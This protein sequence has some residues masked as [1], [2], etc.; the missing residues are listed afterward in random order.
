MLIDARNGQLLE[1][2]AMKPDL[3]V[4]I[5]PQESAWETRCREIELATAEYENRLDTQRPL[6]SSLEFFCSVEIINQLLALLDSEDETLRLQPRHAEAVRTAQQLLRLGVF[7]AL[8]DALVRPG[9]EPESE[10]KV[11]WNW[12]N[13]S[14]PK[15][16][17]AAFARPAVALADS[18]FPRHSWAWTVWREAALLLAGE[19]K[20]TGRQ[21][22][23]FYQSHDFG[24]VC[25][26][27]IS[28]LLARPQA[29]MSELFARRGL[30]FTSADEFRKDVKPL[31]D[32][33]SLLG[34]CAVRACE[35]LRGLEDKDV[36]RLIG[37]L[38]DDF[39]PA[40]AALVAELKKSDGRDAMDALPAAL[41]E[42]WRA[43]LRTIVEARLRTLRDRAA[44]RLS[45]TT[46]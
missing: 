41:E 6:S 13:H 28:E 23:H 44:D 15:S 25:Y 17:V 30:W 20:Y 16:F 34:T 31:L 43:G 7:G 26:L 32:K 9:N 27:T 11:P 35:I 14:P 1:L 12:R 2:T 29:R 45:V 40:A 19:D 37:G 5:V 4:R 22:E 42:C 33:D 8:D 10:F 39:Q 21:L 46:P 18:L 24:P 38:P 36:Q 3:S